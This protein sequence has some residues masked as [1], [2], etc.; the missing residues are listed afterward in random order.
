MMTIMTNDRRKTM[1]NVFNFKCACSSRLSYILTFGF[2]SALHA[3]RRRQ[4]STCP[5]EEAKCSADISLKMRQES[6]SMKVMK[7]KPMF[8][9]SAQGPPCVA[10]IEVC[11]NVSAAGDEETAH[12]DVPSR[13]SRNK[14]SSAAANMAQ[15]QTFRK[16]TLKGPRGNKKIDVQ[17][18]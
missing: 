16:K 8:R 15:I 10:P 5:L 18:A 6:L 2:K 17:K 14:W 3:M 1:I 13:R 11:I 4:T 7:T 12:F 9:N